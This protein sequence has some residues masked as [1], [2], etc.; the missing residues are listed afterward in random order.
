MPSM[1][2]CRLVHDKRRV[3]RWYVAV[4]FLANRMERTG[5][6]RIAIPERIC[7]KISR[8]IVTERNSLFQ[9]TVYLPSCIFDTFSVT[10]PVLEAIIYVLLQY[11][12][13]FATW[14]IPMF[15][16]LNFFEQPRFDQT[17][18]TNHNTRKTR[19]GI[20]IGVEGE[21]LMAWHKRKY[22]SSTV[23]HS[24]R[25]IVFETKYVAITDNRYFDGF[26]SA[27][28]DVLPIRS[29]RVPLFLRSAM[30]GNATS[31]P[32]FEFRNELM[33]NTFVCVDTSSSLDSKWF[34]SQ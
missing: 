28:F 29:F 30:D 33:G 18:T 31:S 7:E 34:F 14:R 20:L 21:W 16:L 3:A 2:P 8:F 22:L 9:L 1:F 19:C 11:F 13:A 12:K 4:V 27:L 23:T 5:T 32:V 26:R 6:E 17:T 25:V 15:L 24:G 10:S